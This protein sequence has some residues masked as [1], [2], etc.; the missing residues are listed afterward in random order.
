[1]MT[2]PCL[3]IRPH[4]GQTRLLLSA[5]GREILHARLPAPGLTHPRAAHTLLEGLSLWVRQ[6][7]A[8]VLSADAQGDSSALGLC[9]ERGFGLDTDHY[10]VQVLEHG[11]GRGLGSFADLRQLGLRGLS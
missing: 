8:V 11:T 7:L 5:G 2:L 3:V 1:M 9:D 10:S 6:P 4:R